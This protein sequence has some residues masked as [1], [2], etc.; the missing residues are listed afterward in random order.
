MDEEV[1]ELPIDIH[2]NKLVHFIVSRQ[3]A[4]KDW[5]ETTRV[6]REQINAAIQ[7]MPEHPEILKLLSGTYINYFHCLKIVKILKQ[8]EADSKNILG[9]YTS[10]RMKDWQAVVKQ[11][12]KGGAYLAESGHLLHQ[13]IAHEI[14]GIQG[15]L[16]RCTQIQQECDKREADL[17]KMA[18]NSQKAYQRQCKQLGIEGIDVRRELID[19]LK[20][21]PAELKRIGQTFSEV[22]SAAKFYLSFVAFTCDGKYQDSLTMLLYIAEHGDVTTYQYLHGEE[23]LSIESPLDSLLSSTQQ[24]KG[25]AL[26]DADAGGI[27]FGDADAGGIDFGDADAGGIELTSN[28]AADGAIDFGDNDGGEIDFGDHQT[29]DIKLGDAEQIDWSAADIA[30]ITVEASGVSG[31]VARGSEALSL[32]L[33]PSTRVRILANL[34]ELEAFLG[35]RLVEMTSAEESLVALNLWDDAPKNLQMVTA[36]TIESQLKLVQKIIADLT[37]PKILQLFLIS[38]SHRYVD[39]LTETLRKLEQRSVVC[40]ATLATLQQR[41]QHAQEQQQQLTK[42]LQ[43]TKTAA[44]SLVLQLQDAISSKYNGR[45]VNI[46]GARQNL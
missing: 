33:N 15:Q 24:S 11:Y 9:W 35:Y 10:Q 28:S 34:Y 22:S 37:T 30:D 46:M 40:P 23:P 4:K 13:Y 43:Q 19:Q 6:V 27:D 2:L 12:E 26:G 38:E 5:A 17:H 7:D 42:K 14:P 45:M 18:Q 3:H 32:L 1:E 16:S 41:R 21:L 25:D 36:S 39:R 20:E 44:K 29:S 8:T 31:G